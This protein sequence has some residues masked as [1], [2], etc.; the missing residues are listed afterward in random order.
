MLDLPP[1]RFLR[2]VGRGTEVFLVLF[3]YGFGEIADQL[4]PRRHVPFLRRRALKKAQSIEPELSVPQR[5][6]L[7]LEEL[8]PTFIKFGQVMSTR[9]DL[10]PIEVIDEL[11]NLQE[12]VPPFPSDAAVRAVE[13]E[14]HAPV[15]E[16]F[17]EFDREPL[18]A[19]SLG[20]V[21]LA[22][23]KDGTRLAVKIRRPTAVRDVER[24]L[25]LML[26]LAELAVSKIKFLEV[27]DP[28]GLVQ[29]FSRTIRR[30]MNFRREG[31]T[32]QEFTRLFSQDAT[33]Y[34]PKVYDELTTEAVLTM[35]Y[36]DGC[37][38]DD[39]GAMASLPI[40]A[41][42]LAVNGAHIF[43][44]M[45]FE[46]GIF[47]GDP[48]PG[49]LRVLPDGRIAFLDYGMVGT[50]GEE[51]REQLVDLFVSV[52]K[53]DVDRAVHLVQTI[54]KPSRPVDDLLLRADVQDFVETYYG[55]PLEQMKIGSMLSDFVDILA[56][57][58]LRCPADLM[59]LIRAVVTLEGVGRSLDPHFNLA[60][61]LAPFVERL[62]KA[63]YDPRRIMERTIDDAKT[64]LG[65][66]HDLPLHFGRTLQK[67]NQDDLRI[68]LEH[69]KLDDFVNE[70]DRSSNRVVV[71]MIT[72]ALIVA[73]ALVLRTGTGEWWLPSLVFA[74]SG[75]LGVWLIW[76]I[77]RSGRL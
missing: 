68:Q 50:L 12:Q 66:I 57:H 39:T 11:K 10:I 40:T 46:F 2:N 28:V 1:L 20:Q 53:P 19:G 65:A 30:E 72:A 42:Q 8:G 34:V 67:L 60:G 52:A 4:N 38:P 61:E 7:V 56:N 31:R 69:R 3:K 18:G 55:V 5:I 27:F 14:L 13:D 45:A 44:R 21:H 29:H 6:R 71:G 62:V 9:P 17:L 35:E 16:L 54:G 76:G 77:L 33:L 51:K 58:G 22:R 36:V 64:V 41:P 73:S 24:D 74:A 49:N 25:A 32:M 75:F 26:D 70:F 47:H 48:H 23:H 63:R 43:M 37:R 59:L 15:D